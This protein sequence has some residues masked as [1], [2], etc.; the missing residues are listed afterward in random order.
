ME[1]T[2]L[3]ME[4]PSNLGEEVSLQ[5]PAELD[6]LLDEQ[7]DREAAEEAS[8]VVEPTPNVPSDETVENLKAQ[9]ERL[10][11]RL[12]KLETKV[13]EPVKTIPVTSVGGED[14]WKSKVEFLLENRDVTEDEYKHLAS[15]ALRNS[16]SVNA[17]SL[18]DAKKEEAE[19]IAYKRKK[20]D[21]KK[22]VPGST[23]QSPFANVMK[24]AEEV[25]KMTP[26]QHAKY[27]AE[28]MRLSENQGI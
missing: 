2:N 21:L 27:E 25:A 14:E 19:Y 20:E 24:P 11:A 9:N 18:R 16:G 22:K 6:R 15:V 3:G 23:T 26:A 7:A 4:N 5:S 1:D 10:Y 13:K 28:M 8:K 17:D 12:K